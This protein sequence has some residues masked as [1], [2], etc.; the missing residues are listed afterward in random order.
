MVQKTI[1]VH[2]RLPKETTR[3]R[4]QLILPVPT[5]MIPK[6]FLWATAALFLVQQGALPDRGFVRAQEEEDSDDW[7]SSEDEDDDDE[8]DPVV[9]LTGKNFFDKTWDKN[10]FIDFYDPQ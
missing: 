1:L 7:G 3:Q 10:V 8:H 6:H 4:R 5:T 2:G 9:R